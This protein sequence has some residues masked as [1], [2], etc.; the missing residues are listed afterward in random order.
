MF[1]RLAL[2]LS[3]TIGSVASPAA[4]QDLGHRFL[5]SIGLDA[6]KQPS[7]GLYVADR[8]AYFA[9][10][11]LRDR[12]GEIIPVEDLILHAATNG[13][14]A[15]FS[16]ELP[17]ISTYVTLAAAF[18]IA[19]VSVDTDRPEASLD[20]FGL[21]DIYLQ[22]ARLGWRLGQLD[23][24]VSY[25]LYVPTGLFD[26]GSLNVSRG[27]LTHELAAGG[28]V[29]FDAGRTAFITALWSYDINEPNRGE[30]DITRGDTLQMQGG[31]GATLF[32][33]A[34]VGVVYYALWQVREDRGADVPPV[35]RG[36]RDRTFG[37]GGEL[38]IR[39][40]AIDGVVGLRYVHDLGTESRPEG[41]SVILFATLLAWRPSQS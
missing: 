3:L 2:V 31:A 40:A 24:I 37:I 10:D 39:V 28:T 21:G 12:T 16:F 15:A 1:S 11:T 41:Q 17:W 22:P 35:L 36:A 34:S 5:G 26:L 33:I 19:Y 32:G 6:G 25:A 7:A 23:A 27:H 38:S 4:A 14:G 13:F 8:F 18:P 30:S 9:A 29:Y 20:T